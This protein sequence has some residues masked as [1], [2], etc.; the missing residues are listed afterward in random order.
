MMLQD[1]QNV[2][3]VLKFY[4]TMPMFCIFCWVS[5]FILQLHFPPGLSITSNV[6]ITSLDRYNMFCQTVWDLQGEP[7]VSHSKSSPYSLDAQLGA[8]LIWSQFLL[9]FFFHE[10][11]VHILSG[12]NNNTCS[13]LRGIS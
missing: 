4:F 7:K 8:Y 11:L 9:G 13:S 10:L 12:F 5:I 1:K 2:I 3:T 6:R